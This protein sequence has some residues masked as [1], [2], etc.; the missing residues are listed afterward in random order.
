M[1]GLFS[2]ILSMGSD[3]EIREFRKIADRVNDIEPQYKKMSDAE[4][5]GQTRR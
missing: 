5:Q 2:K 4:L 1:A 3:K